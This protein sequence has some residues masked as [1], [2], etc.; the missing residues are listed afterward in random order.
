MYCL[1]Q[2]QKAQLL[3]CEVQEHSLVTTSSNSSPLT[4]VMLYHMYTRRTYVVCAI[5]HGS[6]CPLCSSKKQTTVASSVLTLHSTERIKLFPQKVASQDISNG[7][8]GFGMMKTKKAQSY[9]RLCIANIHLLGSVKAPLTPIT[10]LKNRVI[11]LS[12]TF[13]ESSGTLSSAR[14]CSSV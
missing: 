10:S 5:S 2:D 7:G 12:P 4:N 1:F 14:Y 9:I 8:S 11:L 6:K 13:K 3:L